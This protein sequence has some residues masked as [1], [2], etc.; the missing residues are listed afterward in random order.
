MRI[1]LKESTTQN[2]FTMSG[3]SH[4]FIFILKKQIL[5]ALMYLLSHL[6]YIYFFK[7]YLS[8]NIIFYLYVTYSQAYN[9]YYVIQNV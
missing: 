2:Q 7:I 9:I 5:F 4:R 6:L 8:Y 1:S 3:L